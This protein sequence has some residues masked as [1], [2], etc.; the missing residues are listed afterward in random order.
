[1]VLDRGGNYD[2]EEMVISLAEIEHAEFR[3]QSDGQIE[4]HWFLAL[5]AAL[6][7]SI[8]VTLRSMGY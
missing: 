2:H 1:M 8:L 5:G 4:G 6:A 7:V 3:S